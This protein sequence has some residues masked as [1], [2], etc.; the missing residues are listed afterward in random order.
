MMNTA[1]FIMQYLRS[2]HVASSCYAC[3]ILLMIY[4]YTRILISYTLNPRDSH[5]SILFYFLPKADF[6]P[7]IRRGIHRHPPH[8]YVV[9]TCHLWMIHSISTWIPRVCAV[10]ITKF[11]KT[12]NDI[13]SILTCILSVDII[14]KILYYA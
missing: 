10:R 8:I 12:L 11:R 6:S 1:I 9:S 14:D 7:W 4:V 2:I 5:T 13:N 3:V